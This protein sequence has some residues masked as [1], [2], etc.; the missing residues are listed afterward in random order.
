MIAGPRQWQARSA[1]ALIQLRLKTVEKGNRFLARRR[2]R[3]Y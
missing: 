3:R 2:R 1:I